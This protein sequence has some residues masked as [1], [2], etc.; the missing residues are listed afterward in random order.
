MEVYVKLASLSALTLT[1]SHTQRP[2]GLHLYRNYTVIPIVIYRKLAAVRLLS[3]SMKFT[4]CKF[5]GGALMHTICLMIQ[6]F[7]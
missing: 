5:L 4:E 6:Q 7:V 1:H 3:L 2:N